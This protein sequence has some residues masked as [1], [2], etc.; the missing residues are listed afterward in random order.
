MVA[1]EK[2]IK[3]FAVGRFLGRT[4][5]LVS[6][7][8]CLG[9]GGQP[10]GD[11]VQ[12][13]NQANQHTQ[14]AVDVEIVKP[15]R[16]D[17]LRQI[18]LP[19]GI[20]A[21]QRTTLYSKV[22]G[23]LEWI[24]VDIGDWVRKGEVIARLEV[25]E[26]LDQYREVEAELASAK[27]DYENVQAELESAKADY[28]LK[29]ITYK[30]LQSV[31]EEEPDVLPQQTVDEARAKFQV[32][33]AAV[34]VVES[35]INQVLSKIKQV[36]AALNRLQTLMAYAQIKAPFRGV[37]THR[38]VD[39]GALIQA[40][41]ASQNVQPIVTVVS[42]DTLRLFLDI[43]ESEVPFVQVGDKAVI[44]V[45]ALPGKTFEGEVTRF[46]TALD[47]STRTM[48]TEIDIPNHEHRLRPGM[49]GRV[50]VVLEK[51]PGAITIPADA[52]RIEGEMQFVYSVVDGVARKVE[53][54]TGFNDG[55]K[56]EVIKGLEG[57]EDIVV[58]ARGFLA[59]EVKVNSTQY[60]SSME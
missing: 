42:M 15:L 35:K 55:A 7:S 28:E 27:A 44:T 53:V 10:K 21:F 60:E 45:D 39:P 48:K 2:N 1:E 11:S 31:R 47:P 8:L 16:E 40:A 26:M 6:L 43:P 58:A 50:T 17:L 3:A 22:S 37:V 54:E 57:T 32:A 41:T 34:K 29:E 4:L 18:T 38:F 49:Y 5:L 19:A 52:L 56:I 25:P 23:Y 30:R 59:E 12:N 33:R 14:S 9:C 24:R 20:E 36:E 46:A 13:P 51:H